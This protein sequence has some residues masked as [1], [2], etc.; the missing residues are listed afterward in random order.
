MDIDKKPRNFK[1]EDV[2]EDIKAGEYMCVTKCWCK[3]KKS[4]PRLFMPGE[5][6]YFQEDEFIPEHFQ[7]I[8]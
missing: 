3:T 8:F 4:G 2:P 5:T 6:I 7:K 1:E